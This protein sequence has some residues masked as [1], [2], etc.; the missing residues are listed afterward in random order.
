LLA[1][2]RF[3]GSFSATETGVNGR[4]CV[5]KSRGATLIELLISLAIGCVILLAFLG[6][7]VPFQTIAWDLSLLHDRDS[8]LCLAPLLF[9]KWISGAGNNRAGHSWD[10]VQ[11]EGDTLHLKSDTEGQ[12]GFPDGRLKESY[13]SI[14]LRVKGSDLQIRS[15]GGSFQPAFKNFA[16]LQVHRADDRLLSL[17]FE[18]RTDRSLLSTPAEGSKQVA[19]KVYLWNYRPNLFEETP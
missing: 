3:I 2:D 8:S 12:D 19:F 5:P 11:Q 9:C 10:G 7:A 16:G 4:C 6:A 18:G 1:P 15:E 13:E 14:A 17:T